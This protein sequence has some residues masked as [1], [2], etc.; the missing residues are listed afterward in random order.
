MVLKKPAEAFAPHFKAQVAFTGGRGCR[1]G[2]RLD[3]CDYPF[4]V[5]YCGLLG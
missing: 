3:E 2:Q 5:L 4:P 1:L